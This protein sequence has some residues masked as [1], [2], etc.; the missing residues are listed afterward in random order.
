MSAENLSMRNHLVT[1]YH[2]GG[3]VDRAN[4]SPDCFAPFLDKNPWRVVVPAGR[5]FGIIH[6]PRLDCAFVPCGYGAG[7][8]KRW[9]LI[10]GSRKIPSHF[11]LL[12]ALAASCFLGCGDNSL[13]KGADDSAEWNRRL[14]SAIPKEATMADAKKT[15]EEAGFTCEGAKGSGSLLCKKSKDLGPEMGRREWEALF[16]FRGDHVDKIIGTTYL[17]R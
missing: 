8:W 6:T 3:C 4:L 17:I 16:R 2:T 12:I 15:M 10:F 1:Y 13:T 11:I 14:E 9:T 5:I 7:A